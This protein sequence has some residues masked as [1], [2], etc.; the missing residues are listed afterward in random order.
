MLAIPLVHSTA[1]LFPYTTTKAYVIMGLVDVLA[2]GLI[3][4]ML[5]TRLDDAAGATGTAG[6]GAALRC[7][8]PDAIWAVRKVL[9]TLLLADMKQAA[10]SNRA[11]MRPRT[12]FC[13]K[14]L[15]SCTR[16]ATLL[17]S[18]GSLK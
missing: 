10:K 8:P 6:C 14:S 11:G 3:W 15:F 4:L 2:L 16:Y 18:M 9:L 1:F 13:N 7:D 12:I 17:G 5:T